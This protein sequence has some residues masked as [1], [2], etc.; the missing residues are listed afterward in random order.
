MFSGI[1]PAKKG[2]V[3]IEVT[4]HIDS[5]GI[6]NL[7]ARDKQTGQTVESTLKLSKGPKKKGRGD[8][9]EEEANEKPKAQAPAPP[10][11][12]PP[13]PFTMP[14]SGLAQNIGGGSSPAPATPEDRTE[15]GGAHEEEKTTPPAAAGPTQPEA[16][17]QPTSLAPVGQAQSARR[18]P[19]EAGVFSRIMGFFKG[20]FG[21]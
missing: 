5:E 13:T 10:P 11:I 3:Q 21:G 16:K 1:R 8:S 6:L 19:E 12:A 20:L 7:T 4:F 17:P 9:D 14:G 15:P 18:D 2:Q